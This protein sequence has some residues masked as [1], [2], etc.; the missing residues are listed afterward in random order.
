MAKYVFMYRLTTQEA[1]PFKKQYYVL[2]VLDCNTCRNY[3]SVSIDEKF[4]NRYMHCMYSIL[5]SVK[6]NGNHM[7]H[8][9][10]PGLSKCKPVLVFKQLVLRKNFTGIDQIRMER[11]Q[12]E[13]FFQYKHCLKFVGFFFSSGDSPF[14]ENLL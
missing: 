6:I 12:V 13:P 2:S 4:Y 1:I 3:Q 8:H 11:N 5:R 9:T 7:G 14:W 10:L